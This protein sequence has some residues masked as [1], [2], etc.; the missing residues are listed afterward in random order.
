MAKDNDT[1]K[2]IQIPYGLFANLAAYFML[3]QHDAE[4]YKAIVSGITAKYESI[5]NRQLYSTMHSKTATA[6]E[7]EKA[8]QQYLDKVGVPDSFRWDTDYNNNR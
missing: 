4:T 2:N 5:H 6:A 1:P 8:R 3:G 7:Q